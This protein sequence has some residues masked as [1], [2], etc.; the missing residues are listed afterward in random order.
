M[1]FFDQLDRKITLN[2]APTRIISLVPSHTQLLFDLGLYDKVIAVTDY[3]ELPENS[4]IRRIGGTK[5]ADTELISSLQ[6]DL[7]IANKEENT[8][9]IVEALSQFPIWISDVDT[10]PEMYKMIEGIG[11]VTATDH[12]ASL[13]IEELT[14]AM[15]AVKGLYAG[16]V[17]Y[18]IWRKP[19]M[20]A[21]KNTFIDAV[22]EWIGFTNCADETR[23][24][25]I[26]PEQIQ[27]LTPDYIFLSTEPFPFKEKHLDEFKNICSESTV[28]VVNGECF[29]W[30]G[31]KML[32]A[33]KYFP[34]VLK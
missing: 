27:A 13:M 3:C 8:Q 23:Y 9:A 7:I 21:A 2:K 33:T 17:L 30:Y 24:P 1:I 14:S 18:F 16:S 29:S 4:N 12:K 28:K 31:S 19:Y 6:P 25:V 15:D 32:E 11:N 34:L 22:L 10:I 26:T 20:I 5:D